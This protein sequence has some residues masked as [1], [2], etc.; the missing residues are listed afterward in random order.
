MRKILSL[1]RKALIELWREPL[2]LGV[3]LFFPVTIVGFYYVAFGQTKEGL[4]SSLHLLVLNQDSSTEAADGTT[5]MAGNDLVQALREM[6]W[7]G[8]A[9]FTVTEVDGREAAEISLRE[10]KASLLLV[11]PS[12]FT[13]ALSESGLGPVPTSPALV[14]LVG[15]PNSDSYIFAR[16]FIEGLV[17]EF[18]TQATGAVEAQATIAYEFLPGTGTMADFDYGVAGI[19]VFGVA[20]AIIT[21]ATVVVR[22]TVQGTL[23]RLRLSRATAGHV[24]SGVVLSQMIVAAVQVPITFGSAVG[25]GF[26]SNGSLLLAVG[27]VLLFSLSAI[28]LGLL[29]AAFSRNEGDAVNLGS[30]LLVPAVFLSGALFPLP[31]APIATIAGQTIQAYDLL[32]ATHATEALR[33]VLIF[34]EG[35]GAIAYELVGLTVLSTITLA[36]GIWLYHRFKMR[37]T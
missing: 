14:S 16:S 12:N 19:I 17:E 13:R 30:G 5:W 11:I 26:R 32:P 34:G 23:E 25:L 6:E 35:V 33:H 31:E 8:Q 21:T 7:D 18:T 10:R 29:V 3:M 27:I 20:F 28:G 2:L 37:K 9:V 15:D 36:V 24:L 22:E 1:T 4:S